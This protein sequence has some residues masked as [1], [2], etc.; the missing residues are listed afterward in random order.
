[1]I[2]VQ[3]WADVLH[4]ATHGDKPWSTHGGRRL[5]EIIAA[6]P[7]IEPRVVSETVHL[8]VQ[9]KH[10]VELVEKGGG[11]GAT[12]RYYKNIYKGK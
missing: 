8:L 2:D 7:H 1:M 6:V 3:Q 11:K 9:A 10:L 5:S 4:A 12:F